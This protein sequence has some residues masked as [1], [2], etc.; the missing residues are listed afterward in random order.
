MTKYNSDGDTSDF[1][2]FGQ[3]LVKVNCYNSRTSNDTDMKLGP[4]TKPDKRNKTTSKLFDDDVISTNCDL[5]VIFPICGQSGAIQKPDSRRIVCKT[6][7]YIN[8][9]LL[10]CKI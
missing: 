3:S 1:Q 2:I 5:I 10:P 4:V 6:Y 9:N 7:I 8:S